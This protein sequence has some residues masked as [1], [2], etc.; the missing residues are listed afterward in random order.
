MNTLLSFL[1]RLR[2]SWTQADQILPEP[3]TVAK[4]IADI[5]AAN[6][7]YC[8]RPKLENLAEAAMRVRREKVPGC[9]LEAGVALGGSAILLGILKPSIAG[10]KLYDV[11]SMIPPPNEND[12]QDAH[13]RYEVIRSGASAGLGGET[14]YGYVDDLMSKVKSN[15]QRFGLNP[16]DQGIRFIPGLFEQTLHPKKKIALAHIDCDWYDSVRICIERIVPWLSE[17]G[18]IVFDNYSS[19]SGCRKAVDEWLASTSEFEVLFQQRSI[20]LRK[21]MSQEDAKHG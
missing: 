19:Y 1:T 12:E 17:G 9:F 15:L 5:R 21:K 10:L 16:E 18:V 2:K 11:F 6:L 7:S 14:Y 4:L 8:G 3:H 20:G 13:L